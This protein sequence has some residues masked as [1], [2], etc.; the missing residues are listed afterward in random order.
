[1]IADISHILNFLLCPTPREW[2][3]EACKPENLAV[4]LVDHAINEKLCG[5]SKAAIANNP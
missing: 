4:L 1:M 3:E 2:L 5:Y